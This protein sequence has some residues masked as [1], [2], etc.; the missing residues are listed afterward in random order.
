MKPRDFLHFFKTRSGKI[1]TFGALFAGGLV[2]F[3]VIRKHHPPAEDAVSVTPLGTNTVGGKPQV[4]QSVVRPMQAF[5]PPAAKP[6]VATA[7]LPSPGV[8]SALTNASPPP[9]PVV[10]ANQLPTLSPISLFADSSAGIVAPKKLSAAFTPFGRLIPCET[11]I[12]VDSS[13]IQTPIIPQSVVL[14]Q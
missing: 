1:I 9:L 11:I 7:S 2:V 8:P 12:T 14:F 3:G 6:E 5:H 4:V 10:P 13:S